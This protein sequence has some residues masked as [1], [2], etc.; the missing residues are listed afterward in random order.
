MKGKERA[1]SIARP[2]LACNYRLSMA[3]TTSVD[4]TPNTGA[5]FGVRHA[6]C[7][8]KRLHKARA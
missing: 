5:F 1:G 8:A 4:N 3:V 2:F 6:V 7:N